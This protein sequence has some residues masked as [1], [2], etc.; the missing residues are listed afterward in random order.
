MKQNILAT[1]LEQAAST[2]S[3]RV[4]L[5]GEGV[6]LTYSEWLDRSR[7]IAKHLTEF[8]LI[9]HEPVMVKCSNHPLDFVAFLGVW[10]A[11][12][13][14]APVHRTT[15]DAVVSAMQAKADCQLCVDLLDEVEPLKA[16]RVQGE[17]ASDASRRQNLED[18]ALIIFTSGS[19]G[20]PKAAVLSHAAF[21]G[22][23]DQN[24]R[25]LSIQSDDVTMLVLNNTF[26]FGI[27][28]SLL[29]LLAGGRLLTQAK[30]SPADFVE[31]LAREG[32]SFLGVV[33]TMVRATFSALSEGEL[34]NAKANLQAVAR[35]RS[36]VIGG[37]PLGK[38]L[39]QSLRA[40]IHP[41]ALFDIY[42]LTETST[43][44]FVLQPR[45]FDTHEGTIGQPFPGIE[46]RV[47]SAADDEEGP[48]ELQLRSPYLM[49]GYLG[50]E[51]LSKAAFEDGWFRTGDLAVRHSDGYVSI[52]GRLKDVIVRGGNKVTPVEVER[53]LT[54]CP[55]VAA[56]LVTGTSDPVMGQRIQALL[57]PKAG[58]E[59]DA[60]LVR[61]ELTKIL[62]KFKHPDACFVG[63]ELPT[64][65]TGKVD[66]GQLAKWLATQSVAPLPFWKA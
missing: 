51:E 11:G 3:D 65:R 25:L 18:G 63:T 12:G 59:I 56:A 19:T 43:C 14:V 64:G 26:S 1:R 41:A 34:A 7:Q 17:L 36:V 32:V 61:A 54:R 28:V 62:E 57:V 53:A 38:D 47:V 21:S 46:Y 58:G 4:A 31:S 9:E 35:L 6:K 24:Q 23:L 22:K 44:D 60:L 37:E 10:L 5:T 16:L 40:F 13:V 42:G 15:P 55:G 29:T 27:W 20:L 52:V 49:S 30:F 45:D 39:S 2:Y 8:G 33:P 48:G 66:R 50:D